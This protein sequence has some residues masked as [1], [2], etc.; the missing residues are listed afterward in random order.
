VSRAL[1]A[2]EYAQ[3]VAAATTHGAYS[4][5]RIKAKARA[6]RRRFLSRGGLRASELDPVS[7]ELLHLWSRGQAQL[8]LLE[9]G[10]VDGTRSYWTAYNATRRVLERLERR[11]SS[12]GLDRRGPAGLTVR[13]LHALAEDEVALW[14]RP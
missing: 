3:R 4:A 1:N 7:N 14:P 10:G 13:E 8:D 2:S 12:L 5:S 11:L 6:H 9:L